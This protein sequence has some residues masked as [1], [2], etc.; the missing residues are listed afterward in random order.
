MSREA[1]FRA[2]ALRRETTRSFRE[3][4]SE[5]GEMNVIAEVKKASPSAGMIAHEFDPARIAKDYAVAGASAVSVLTDEQ[6][7][8]GHADDLRAVRD[9]IA[10]PVLRKDFVVHEVQIAEAAA[11]GADAVLLI[12]AALTDEELARFLLRADALGLDALVEVHTFA[13]LDRALMTDARIIGIN[14]RNLTTFEV[15]LSVTEQ[16]SDDVPANI[17]LV[18]ESGIKSRA[19]VERVRAC[20]VNA[21]LVGEALMRG[22]TTIAALLGREESDA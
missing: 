7:F 22:D 21:V 9:A 4:I 2:A 10:L 15:D 16:L 1:E 3:A 13:E 8:S 6:F 5:R 14:N 12:V 17:T 11:M 19:D 20:G 18:S